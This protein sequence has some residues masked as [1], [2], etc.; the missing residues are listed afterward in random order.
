MMIKQT[1]VTI[2]LSGFTSF[3]VW[4]Q[5]S[6]KVHR[7]EEVEVVSSHKPSAVR[8]VSPLQVITADN[9]LRT[10]IQSVSDA[11]RRIPGVAVKDFGG[12]G[13]LKTVSVRGLGSQHT[14]VVYDGIVMNDAQSAEVDISRFSLDNVSMITLG[15]GQSSDIFRP[16]KAFGSAGILDIKTNVP[17]LSDAKYTGK[18]NIQTGSFGLFNPTIQHTHR[19]SKTWVVSGMADWQRA[20]GN[21]PFRFNS[22]DGYEK[23]K[24]Y[25]SDV[26]IW[27][28]EVNMFGDLKSAGSIKLKV[29]YYDSERGLPGNTISTNTY[30]QERLWNKDFV[31]YLNYESKPI[32][33]LS[34]KA[35]GKFARLYNKYYN[36]NNTLPGGSATEKYTQFEYYGSVAALYELNQ[37]VSFSLAQDYTHSKLNTNFVNQKHPLRNTSQTAFNAQYVTDWVIATAGLLGT[38]VGE[39]VETGEKP[40][41]KKRLSPAIGLSFKPFGF[42]L[43]PRISYKDI[44]RIPT[45]SDLYYSQIGNVKLRPEKAR[46]YNAGLTYAGN[47]GNQPHFFSISVDGYINKVKDKIV[48][49]TPSMFVF[50]MMNV[51]NVTIKGADINASAEFYLPAGMKLFTNLSYSYQ[52]A[53]NDETKD[54]IPYTPRNS[55]SGS[56]SFENRWVN[57]SYSFVASGKRYSKADNL[58]IYKIDAYF[59]QTISVNKIIEFNKYKL[60]LQAELINLGNKNYEIIKLYPMPGRSFRFSVQLTY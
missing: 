57:L 19:A 4:A 2:L 12:I 26:D 41:D 43:R 29:N 42:G 8:S 23:R 21:Y 15:I 22:G 27:R 10:G 53:E 13:G 51:D 9:I 32:G 3:G 25:N 55:G 58:P 45:F 17:A 1:F 40:A 18:I 50:S 20:D 52:E 33:K 54:Q 36:K 39:S 48:I 46:L 28:T 6:I 5:D 59:D 44:F 14:A 60:R 7:I 30:A 24:R 16:A 47:F 38:F 11:V 56:I 49:A 37:T 34:V 31:S 35:L